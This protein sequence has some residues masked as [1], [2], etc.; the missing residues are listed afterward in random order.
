MALKPIKV[1]QLNK[2]IGRVLQTDP[3][4]G[5]V[6]VTGEISNL[7]YHNS[8]H[9]YFTL[10]DETSKINCFMPERAAA[11]LHY[12]LADGMEIVAD[13]YVSV[14]EKGGYYSF[15]VKGVEIS[16]EGN[17]ARAFKAMYEKLRSEGIFDVQH[18]KHLPP[19]PEKICVITSPTGAAVRD[20]LKIIR[21]RNKT[22]SVIVYP[23]LVQ[24]ERAASEI[25][26]AID[27]VNARF[28][29]VDIIITGRGG[30]SLEELWAFNEEIVARSIY[31]SRI[32]VISAVG[33]ET[34]FSISDY[35]ADVRAETPTAAAAMAVPDT[36]QLGYLLDG[37]MEQIQE[38][39]KR[40]VAFKKESV[41]YFSGNM[42]PGFVQ[43]MISVKRHELDS[44]MRDAEMHMR[45]RL[46]TAASEMESC[47][48]RLESA[49]PENIIRRGYSVVRDADTG[50]I[51]SDIRT[52]GG[53]RSIKIDLYG[54]TITAD[55]V[56]VEDVEH[57]L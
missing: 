52:A 24:G 17:L 32:P 40:I 10:K 28:S 11:V 43:H 54:G 50:K 41:R 55:V 45:K 39:F 4:L 6:S 46:D 31:E 27:D 21:S 44:I 47:L 48:V 7:K 13:G 56:S 57:T 36:T 15:N 18:K 12:E 20:I 25:A 3:I 53:V 22:V 19:F 49:N 29:D 35:A 23:C 14:Y 8:G 9:V 16:G 33:H 26:A 34:D 30:G 38:R 5:G 2:Y 1:S 51:I 37:N 42:L